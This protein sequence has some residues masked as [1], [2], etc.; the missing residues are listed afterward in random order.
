MSQS[1]YGHSDEVSHLRSQNEHLSKLIE[2]Q[3]V[4]IQNLQKE[5]ARLAAERDGLHDKV[6]GLEREVSRK[7][8]VA[9]LFISPETLRE[10]AEADDAITPVDGSP[11]PIEQHAQEPISPMPPPRSPYRSFKDNSKP[12]DT[13]Q[14]AHKEQLQHQRPKHLNFT[15]DNTGDHVFDTISPTNSTRSP[16]TSPA[17][18]PRTPTSPRIAIME[19]DAQIYAK[20]HQSTLRKDMPPLPRKAKPSPSSPVGDHRAFILPTPSKSSSM[21]DVR[22]SARSRDSMMPPVRAALEHDPTMR[23]ASPPL[24]R[25][26]NH[27]HHH[28]LSVESTVSLNVPGAGRS[29]REST[30]FGL[31]GD[32]PAVTDFPDSLDGTTHPLKP[33]VPV[34]QEPEDSN[35]ADSGTAN[36]FR[37]ITDVSIKLVGS[38]IKTNDRGKEVISFIISVG[39]G[40]E[41]TTSDFE[42]LWRVEKLYSDFLSLDGKLRAQSNRTISNKIGKLP[43]KAL[44]TTNAPSKADQ[45]KVALEQY[46]QHVVSLPL[47]DPSDLCRF[48]STDIIEQET[49][50]TPG[51]KEGYLTKRGKN[52]GG[53]K[54]RYFVLNGPAL[55]YY[56][57]KDGNQLGSIRLTNAQIGRQTPGVA[58]VSEEN[59]V[60]R[61][62]FLIV[63][64]KR[65]GSSHVARHILCAESDADRDDWVD[66]LFQNIMFEDPVEPRKEDRS[67]T[68][69]RKR[70]EKPRKLSKG[71]IRAIA[72]T[73]IS[74]MKFDQVAD[75]EKLTGGPTMHIANSSAECLLESSGVA[76]PGL[77]PASSA[78]SDSTDS[79]LL[80]TSLPSTSSPIGMAGFDPHSQIQPS[81]MRTSFD[82]QQVMRNLQTPRPTLARRSSMVNLLNVA[83]EEA[84]AAASDPRVRP[85]S[86]SPTPN[87]GRDSDESVDNLADMPEKKHKNKANRMTFWGK[88]MFSS[89]NNASVDPNLPNPRPTTS[90]S[91]TTD[92]ARNGITAPAASGFRSFLSRTSNESTDRLGQRNRTAEDGLTCKNKQVFGVPLDEAVRVSRVSEGYELPAVV[93]RC[94]EYLNAKN[95]VLEEGLYRLS[96]RNVTMKSLKERFN[97]EG[98]VNLLASKEEY[99]VHV[100]AGLLKMWLRELPT[101]VL[102]R[103]YRVDFLHVIDLLDRKDRV[104]ELGRLVSL[105]P[106]AN[107]TLLR[108][109]TAHL[110]SVVQHADINKMNVRNVSIVFSPTLGIPATIFNLFMSEFEYIFWT[111]E[112]GDAAPRMLE[113]E[114]VVQVTACEDTSAPTEEIESEPVAPKPLGRKPTLKLREEHGRSN[115]NSVNYMDGAP[116]AIVDLEKNIDGPPVL[117][118][119]EDDVDDLALTAAEPDDDDEENKQLH[120]KE[121]V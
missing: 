71:E 111:T 65:A 37:S 76:I 13:V 84:S 103:E 82:Q 73:P 115:R 60:Y 25:T 106:L 57:S 91:T 45:R 21:L 59:N 75:V 56:E 93:F 22:R 83:E 61:H 114:E 10:I 96:G 47:E 87:G 11:S 64:Q 29:K 110:I 90:S 80:S 19:K 7:Q 92:N 4:T 81:Q 109:L 118:E 113:D 15:T 48:L 34:I 54:T 46:L 121:I 100:V 53:W 86:R 18:G 38:H 3:R 98:D 119:D 26:S 24:P 68:D 44:F 16:P 20:Y 117:D 27:H 12:A 79:S 105:L 99:D 31:R 6:N 104:N 58:Q 97:Q 120:E 77:Q 33:G 1:N 52:F 2:K 9:S 50:R 72:A 67:G 108:A 66:A 85:G 51:R 28:K 69:R 41:T 49:C 78:S 17:P 88:K 62:A 70:I 102:T 112:D 30:I 40:D 23:A 36:P 5:N 101:S 107:Y 74:H 116:N 55:E 8:R 95:A 94:I 35:A 89:S 32:Y 42:E 63:E 39:K 43:D 14:V